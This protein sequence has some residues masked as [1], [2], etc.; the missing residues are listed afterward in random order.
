MEKIFY[1]NV[2]DYENSEAAIKR[3]FLTHFGISKPQ[4]DRTENGKP[5]IKNAERLFFSVSHTQNRLFVAVC[6]ENVGIDAEYATRKTHYSS[7]I[8][9]FSEAE[10]KEIDCDEAFLRHWTAKESAV[11]W[12]GG[13][14]SHDLYKLVY[15]GGKLRYGEIELPVHLS[16]LRFEEYILSVCSEKDFSQAEW[17]P[18]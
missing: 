8:R 2:C 7:I 11:K 17:I 10:R 13:T 4:I 1:A 3:I 9:K 15:T 12:L 18:F 14:L 16:H 6:D 5:F